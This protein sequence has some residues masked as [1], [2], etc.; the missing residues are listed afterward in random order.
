MVAM[1]RA[2]IRMTLTP[3][4]CL[5]QDVAASGGHRNRARGRE[6]RL[7]AL[8]ICFWRG[9]ATAGGHRPCGA[10]EP[11]QSPVFGAAE[12]APK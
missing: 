10:A 5:G 9:G 1:C 7:K 4:G 6:S 12:N 3:W 11:P 8:R 2:I